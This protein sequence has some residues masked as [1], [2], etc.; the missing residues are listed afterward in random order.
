MG[1]TKRDVKYTKIIENRIVVKDE[2]LKRLM[3][4]LEK[5]T[6]SKLE[7]SIENEL[8]E[9]NNKIKHTGEFSN[10]LIS[11]ISKKEF[12]YQF[13]NK[14]IQLGDFIIDISLSRDKLFNEIEKKTYEFI[15]ALSE[16]LDYLD[17]KFEKNIELKKTEN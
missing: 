9:L 1:Y 13:S 5:V 3:K 8:R 17:I 16:L 12:L 15:Y 11:D 14:N 10:N 2:N 6:A 4:A 7:S